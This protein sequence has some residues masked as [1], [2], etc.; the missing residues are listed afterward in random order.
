MYRLTVLL[1]R[2]LERNILEIGPFG[3]I[4][5]FIRVR[6]PSKS[7]KAYVNF[8]WNS[9]H[10]EQ[11]ILIPALYL[12]FFQLIRSIEYYVHVGYK[13]ESFAL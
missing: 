5:F 8:A 4:S 10:Y 2:I 3:L 9:G 7:L 1:L 12:Y 6:D 13:I 11:I